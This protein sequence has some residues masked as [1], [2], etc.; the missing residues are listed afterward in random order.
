MM[1]GIS[2]VVTT[3]LYWETLG[4]LR[5]TPR[6]DKLREAINNL[7]LQKAERRGPINGRDHLFATKSIPALY[8]LWHCSISRNPDVV[9]F[10]AIKDDT[11]TLGMLG[12]HDDFPNHGSRNL[13][14]YNSVGTRIWNSIEDGHVPSPKWADLKWSRPADLIAHPEIEELSVSALSDLLGVLERETEDAPL[15]SR[16]HG[17]DILDCDEPTIYSWLEEVDKAHNHVCDLMVRPRY[18][19]DADVSSPFKI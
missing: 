19:L 5:G 18:S 15:F 16:L 17:R 14:R 10:Y 7:V 6:Y 9:L 1:K 8:G 4:E 12:N 13:S 3:S 2:K 11:I